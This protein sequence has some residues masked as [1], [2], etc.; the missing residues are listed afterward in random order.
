MRIAPV[1]IGGETTGEGTADSL[2]YTPARLTDA[3]E[4]RVLGTEFYDT[5]RN[6]G[7]LKGAYDKGEAGSFDIYNLGKPATP[8]AKAFSILHN[9]RLSNYVSW[10]LWGLI[11]LFVVLAVIG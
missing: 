3:R 9:G 7:A 2:A 4:T 8:I 1:Y 5:I 6:M 11:I 10:F